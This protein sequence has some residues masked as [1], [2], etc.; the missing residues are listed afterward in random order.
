MA[1]GHAYFP[2]KGVCIYCRKKN[3]PLKNEHI[4]P[5][6][7][8]G[9]T[10]LRD[11]SCEACEDIT[12]K[13]EQDIAR[14]MW[15]DARNHFD[16][17]S[18][19]KKDRKTHI[20]LSDPNDFRRKIKVPYADYPA[21]MFFYKMGPAGLMRGLPENMDISSLW[22]LEAISDHEKM[23]KFKEKYGIS[24]SAK[25]KHSPYSFARML[26]KIGYGHTLTQLDLDDFRSIC[27]PYILGEKANIS[28][29]V[30]GSF[31]TPAPNL[32]AGYE[33]RN[34]GFGT[35]ERIMI[36]A[37]VRIFS[38]ACTPIYHVV[39][40]DVIGKDNVSRVLQ[41]MGEIEVTSLG[42]E[43]E[44]SPADAGDH[45]SSV[46]PLPFWNNADELSK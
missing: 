12:K 11:A 9:Q 40:G 24:M 28:Y 7:I 31:E 10:V 3:V 16:A 1:H 42:P 20:F 15:G 29:I 22:K 39:I 21:P 13:F 5:Y 6:S 2:S 36:T 14:D 19:R 45:M 23:M 34:Y 46:W 37:E 30:G 8:G 4:V 25:F 18:R 44:A 26:A 27:V 17:P 35:N 32:N 38:N 33:L 41:K 43:S